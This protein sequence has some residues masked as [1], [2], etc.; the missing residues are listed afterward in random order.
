MRFLTH[1]LFL[2][3]LILTGVLIVG[4]FSYRAEEYFFLATFR[5]QSLMFPFL[6][7]AAL[8]SLTGI[9]F[10]FSI[11]YLFKSEATPDIVEISEPKSETDE[12]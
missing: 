10:T 6:G 12:A 5:D 9:F 2:I 1:F 4:N 3:S 11:R 8:G 7:F